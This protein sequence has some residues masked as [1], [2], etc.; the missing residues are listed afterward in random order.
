MLTEERVAEI[1]K[2]IDEL[3]CKEWRYSISNRRITSHEQEKLSLYKEILLAAGIEYNGN[4]FTSVKYNA[5]A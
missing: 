1:K 5:A 4:V 3:A 2:Q